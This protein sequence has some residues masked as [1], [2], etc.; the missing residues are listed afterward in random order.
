MLEILVAMIVIAIG[1][2]GIAGLQASALK[3]SKASEG[4]FLAVQL[5]NDIIERLRSNEVGLRNGEFAGL[6]SMVSTACDPNPPAPS[7]AA[8]AAQQSA[9]WRN[10]IACA[11]P[12]GK[13]SVVI[14]NGSAAAGLTDVVVTIQ[15][16]DSRLNGGSA[17][18]ELVTRT[19]I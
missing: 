16:D 17:T 7:T 13:G 8:P 5:A 9:A 12:N 1:V 11:L 2:L 6:S 14:T 4:R 15:W 3:Y 10:A 19:V 18:E